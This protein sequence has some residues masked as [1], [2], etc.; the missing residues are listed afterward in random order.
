MKVSLWG[1]DTQEVLEGIG[2]F[3]LSE[4]QT[5]GPER[6][7]CTVADQLPLASQ[8]TQVPGDPRDLRSQ[9]KD[10]AHPGR[11]LVVG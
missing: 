1:L 9:G 6:E 2:Y 4:S 11:C 3:V 8:S 10:F 5:R 7:P